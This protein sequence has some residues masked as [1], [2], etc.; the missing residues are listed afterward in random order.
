MKG[1][2]EARRALGNW[3]MRT[4]T[5]TGSVELLPSDRDQ[6]WAS[7]QGG[8]NCDWQP[9]ENHAV[10]SRADGRQDSSWSKKRD[11]QKKF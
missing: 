3:E 6:T 9:Y 7:G 5:M 4:G 11:H 1:T 8:E 2:L 10:S